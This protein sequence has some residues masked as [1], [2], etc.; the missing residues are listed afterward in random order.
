MRKEDRLLKPAEFKAVFE[1]KKS[2]ADRYLVLYT[3]SRPG[4]N[5]RVGISV[6]K[7]VAGSV[8][9][10]RLKRLVR[11]A[12]RLNRHRIKPGYN[13]IIILRVAAKDIDFAQV[14]R[15]FLGLL[16]RAGLLVNV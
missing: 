8:G 2:C 16:G 7:K 11:E 1:A 15:S 10:N 13:L 4:S 14:Q 12:V 3:L 6:S 9:R 5:S